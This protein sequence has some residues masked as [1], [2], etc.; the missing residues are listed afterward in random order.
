MKN[1][2]SKKIAHSSKI[3]ENKIS[4]PIS[5][6]VFLTLKWRNDSA[7]GYIL[8]IIGV[9]VFIYVIEF[10]VFRY[11]RK[12]IYLSEYIYIRT[13]YIRYVYISK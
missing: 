5:C 8:Q 3:I 2:F 1:K 9:L 12:M 10:Q 13:I 7:F 4:T 6:M 11:I